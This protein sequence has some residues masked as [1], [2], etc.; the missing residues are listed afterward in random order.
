MKNSQFYTLLFWAISLSFVI[1]SSSCNKEEA[2]QSNTS[3][4]SASSSRNAGS[5]KKSITVHAGESIQAAVDAAAPGS[6]IQIAPGTYMESITVNKAGISLVGNGEAAVVIQNPGDEENGIQVN[7]AGDGFVLKNVTVK[8]FE[9][10]GVL[11]IRVDNFTISHVTTIDNG[12]YG[13]FPVLSSHGLIE[14][15]TA[16]GHTDTGI[17]VGQSSDI[18][19]QYNTAYAN[20]NGLEIENSANVKATNNQSYNNVCGMLIDLL[21]GKT[22]KTSTNVYV[23]YNHVFDNNHEN[24]GEEGSLESVIPSGLGILILGTDQ[25]TVEHNTVMHNNFSGITVFSTLVLVALGGATPDQFD[26]EPNPD[27]TRVIKNV[28]QQ[29]GAAPPVLDIPLP[30]VDLLWD[31]SGIGN[32]WSD[33]VF[34]TSYPSPLP[35]CN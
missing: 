7:D 11:L 21:P 25:T 35:S 19:M 29:N 2:T 26:I 22:V 5:A 23:G 3:L 6:T 27:G 17:Y 28:A 8:N 20:V 31:G 12:E 9:E 10:N 18:E 24:F 4:S 16:T 33:N 32:C 15:C 13:L 30:G 1:V 34:K 14:H